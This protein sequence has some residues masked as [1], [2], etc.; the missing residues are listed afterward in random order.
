MKKRG[1]QYSIVVLGIIGLLVGSV[2]IGISR[3]ARLGEGALYNRTRLLVVDQL[4]QLQQGQ[5]AD[6]TYPYAVI[7]LSGKVHYAD[8]L[9]GFGETVPLTETIQMDQSFANQ[10][11]GLLK[12]TFV[13][14]K[15]GDAV[16]FV[17]FLIPK[18]AVY[19]YSDKQIIGLLFGPIMVVILIIGLGLVGVGIYFY[20]NMLKPI[21]KICVSA[22]GI[23][24]G[25]YEQPVRETLA[26]Q[27]K[28]ST[29]GDLLYVFELMRDE[30]KSKQERENQLKKSQKELIACISHD[31]KTPLSSVKAYSEGLRD[32]VITN[33]DKLKRYA[34]VIVN[35][36]D[37]LNTMIDDLLEH[38]K[39]ELRALTI[40]PKEIYFGEY[41]HSLTQEIKLFVEKNQM[42]CHVQNEVPNCI[43]AIDVRRI[44]QVMENLVSNC[45]KYAAEGKCI[46]IQ[47]N[48]G[49]AQLMIRVKDKGPGIEYGDIPYVFNKFY[50]GEKSRK[51]VTGSGL[52]LSICKYII[53][54]HGGHI[55]CESQIG[56]GT[57]FTI[58]LP[59][60]VSE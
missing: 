52:G 39:A 28:N 40:E 44:T 18:E 49:Q 48:L 22:E 3:I 37:L 16:A 60:V 23:I 2:L 8:P 36:A 12:S 45:I 1:L 47:S 20:Y 33:P 25:D 14:E 13:L 31:L 54:A 21:Q 9:F 27:V 24:K 11:K 43:V 10:Y 58:Y 26:K 15:Q 30:L 17:V 41:F 32:G 34:E 6:T 57:C 35:K 29:I 50:R 5:C 4:K 7:D 56:E 55:A 19:S 51:D 42:T 53:E 59:I 38:S 46:E